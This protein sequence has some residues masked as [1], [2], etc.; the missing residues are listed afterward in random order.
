MWSLSYL[1]LQLSKSQSYATTADWLYVTV[2]P[3]DLVRWIKNQKRFYLE[4]R[5][6]FYML[7]NSNM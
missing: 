5:V 6:V 4:R 3:L 7:L 2:T 1:L